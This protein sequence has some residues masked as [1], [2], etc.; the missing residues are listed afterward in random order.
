MENMNLCSPSTIK[1]FCHRNGCCEEAFY[2]FT[3]EQ[4]PIYCR[5]HKDKRMNYIKVDNFFY[6]L[7][8]IRYSCSRE[9]CNLKPYQLRYQNK[10]YCFF[11]APVTDI[12]PV[13]RN[14]HMCTQDYSSENGWNF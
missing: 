3:K 14:Y 12:T 11:H 9:G 1:F 6:N 10:K 5:F 13:C 2:N 4:E 8:W 7:I